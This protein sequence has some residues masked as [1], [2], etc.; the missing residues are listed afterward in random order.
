MKKSTVPRILIATGLEE[1]DVR[2]ATGLTA[3]DPFALLIEGPR[4]HMV[5]SAL[6][7]ARARR[8]CPT[9]M[10]HTPAT[11]FAKAPS[12]RP[13][14]A[15]QVLALLHQL[16][17]QAVT[18]GPWFP[19]GVA[20]ALEQGGIDVRLVTTPPFPK[21]AIKTPHEIACIAKSQ[22]AA[23]AAM[24]AAIAAIRGAELSASG[25]LRADGRPLTSQRLKDIIEQT[26]LARR[27]TADGTIVAVGPQG[28]RPHDAGSGPLRTNVPVV[29]DIF[30][31]DKQTGYWGDLTRTV[32]RGRATPDVRRLFQTVL[33][34]QKQALA[35]VRPGVKSRDVQRAVEEYFTQSGYPTRL[36][37]PGRESGFIHSLGHGVG[38]D[39]HESPGLR[40]EPTRLVA[41]NVL[42]VEPGLY[43]P[44]LGGIRIED[45]VAVTLTGCKLLAT[46]SK[47]LEYGPG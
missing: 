37:P 28:A 43:L 27:C 7:A 16:K 21:R 30:P 38:L 15:A 42:T 45:T 6:E 32:V 9:A 34:A 31:R 41:G 10:L 39:I 11:L 29:I 33:A 22:R 25:L 1:S 36:T 24:R 18:V 8:A 26:L 14:L 19:V 17:A 20:R 40:D 23:V 35:L 2:Y 44:G 5:V 13:T 12:R 4:K 3:P 47:K 46:C